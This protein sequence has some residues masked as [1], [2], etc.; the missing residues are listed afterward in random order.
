MEQIRPRSNDHG[1]ITADKELDHDPQDRDFGK[2]SDTDM[3]RLEIV[4]KPRRYEFG[5]L[6]SFNNFDVRSEVMADETLYWLF[7]S[8]VGSKY[9]W[10]EP[11][12]VGLETV[13]DCV[14]GLILRRK[15][16]ADISNCERI[17]ERV[18]IFVLL[19]NRFEIEDHET[20][21]QL[22]K[23]MDGRENRTVTIV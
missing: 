9:F 2:L 11:R 8:R 10:Q 20:Y 5:K 17:F 3:G 7:I 14:E 19:D 1:A 23:A 21:F 12:P 15:N 16:C 6:M 13:P 18:G 4:L 22:A